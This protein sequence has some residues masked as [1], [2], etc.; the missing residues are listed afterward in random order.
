MKPKLLF[1]YPNQFGYHTDSYKYCEY[2]RDTYNI[3]YVCFDQGL[4]R[5]DIP[6][7]NVIYKPCITNKARRLFSYY[8]F[9]IRLSR[10]EKFDI[11]FTIQFKLCF[12]LGLFAKA[13]IKILDYR[14]GDL[15]IKDYSRK[16]GNV[17]MSF[18]S[19]FFRNISVISEG[20]RILLR[21]RKKTHIL[22]LGA[23]IFSSEIRNY[24]ELNL[25][26]VG[27]L[28]GR[29]IGQTIT[30]L[31]L[32]LDKY[33]ELS[34]QISYTIIGFGSKQEETEICDLINKNNLSGIVSF[35]G[36]KKYTDLISYFENCNVGVCYV[37]ITPYYDFQ[38]VTKL[39]EYLLSG[40]AVI[41]TNTHENSHIVN[42]T[43]GILINDTS[44][45]FCEGLYSIYNSRNKFSSSEI[46][47]S[48]LSYTWQNIVNTNLKPYLLSLKK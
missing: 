11:I 16:L 1:V 7:I 47:Q 14:S 43:N 10:K 41:S 13:E 38:P 25:L 5:M 30:G 36:R 46:R 27:S 2:L 21:L 8:Y 19:L 28:S 6:Q 22:P 44:D 31:S 26:Y 37:P 15:N 24:D 9:I 39:F 42:Q 20:L 33:S 34:K 4:E 29:N 35:L 18:D 45:A 32:F 12:L 48:M 23:D 17:L 3:Y 40:M